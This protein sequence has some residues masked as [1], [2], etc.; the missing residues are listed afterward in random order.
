MHVSHGVTKCGCKN[1]VRIE[2]LESKNVLGNTYKW[3]EDVPLM[4]TPPWRAFL[5]SKIYWIITHAT[6][7]KTFI[8]SRPHDKV[9]FS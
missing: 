7:A 9:H 6:S 2:R 3:L 4:R 1:G 5:Q 8:Y